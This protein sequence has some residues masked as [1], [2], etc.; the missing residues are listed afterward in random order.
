M[1]PSDRYSLSLLYSFPVYPNRLRLG[2]RN[3]NRARGSRET[4]RVCGCAFKLPSYLCWVSQKLYGCDCG[5]GT[6][7]V[8]LHILERRLP[9]LLFPCSYV[10]NPHI[11]ECVCLG[12]GALLIGES[13][14]VF[15][16]QTRLS[17]F[18]GEPVRLDK[19][20]FVSILVF[21]V[22]M[23]HYVFP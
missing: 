7:L 9:P 11:G 4:V 12:L 18:G 23:S 3:L 1:Y 8:C 16:A 2:S 13:N 14:S 21:S 10:C 20:R 15:W 6:L 5:E 17:G 19:D 22:L